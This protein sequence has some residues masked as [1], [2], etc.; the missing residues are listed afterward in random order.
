M[1]VRLYTV[2]LPSV[3]AVFDLSEGDKVRF[4]AARV[5][6]RQPLVSLGQGFA[7]QF[8]RDP[9]DDLFK[10]TNGSRG[11]ADLDPFRAYQFDLGFESSEERRVGKACVGTCRSRWSPFL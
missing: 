11:H 8:T 9:A 3:N 2:F 1:V 4:S 6:A 5:V 10:F 7:T